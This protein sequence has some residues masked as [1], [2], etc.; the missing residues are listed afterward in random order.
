MLQRW[1]L[2]AVLLAAGMPAGAG[3]IF[4]P[5]G[6]GFAVGPGL[7]SSA[8]A[9]IT[10]AAPN[11]DNVIGVGPNSV[12]IQKA[13][14][15]VD[16]IDQVLFVAPSGGVTEYHLNE[17]VF[18]DTG[19]TWLDYHLILG[20]GTGA[21]FRARRRATEQF[22]H[23]PAHDRCSGRLYGIHNTAIPERAGTIDTLAGADCAFAVLDRP[24]DPAISRCGAIQS[25]LGYVDSKP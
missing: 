14:Q 7:G 8:V 15:A 20:F 22:P 5:I 16:Y 24:N 21:L 10:T 4:G 17:F 23:V 18:N 11:I 19:Q 12:D 3:I 25:R 2:V 1:V 6:P 9:M 13:F